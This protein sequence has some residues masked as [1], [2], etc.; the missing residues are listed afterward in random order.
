MKRRLHM[1]RTTAVAL[2]MAAV[3][4]AWLGVFFIPVSAVAGIWVTVGILLAVGS[5]LALQR[6][7]QDRRSVGQ[8]LHALE[9]PGSARN[10]AR[11]P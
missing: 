8:I 9:N 1:F 6:Q 11:R 7:S 2:S 4:G 3:L 10:A 5:T